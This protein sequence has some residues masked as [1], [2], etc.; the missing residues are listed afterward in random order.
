MDNLKEELHDAVQE[1]RE[2]HIKLV[3]EELKQNYKLD[4]LRAEKKIKPMEMGEL[5]GRI[6]ELQLEQ[7]KNKIEA[8]LQQE[9]ILKEHGMSMSV[10]R[11]AGTPAT[12][13]TPDGTPGGSVWVQAAEAVESTGGT[14]WTAPSDTSPVVEDVSGDSDTI[15]YVVSSQTNPD[16]W[17][18]VWQS[19]GSNYFGGTSGSSS[20]PND[21]PLADP[22]TGK[23]LR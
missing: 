13:D 11:A 22:E 19:G 6:K 5:Y 21:I 8:M 7:L 20:S 2:R 16:R 23:W 9:K 15:Q 12:K 14:T 4:D 10:K 1:A 3:A 18:V 17:G